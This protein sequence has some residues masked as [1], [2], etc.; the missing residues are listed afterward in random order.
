MIL[1]PGQ[2]QAIAAAKDW[3]L[4]QT[5]TTLYLDGPAGT[6]KTTIAKLLA[7]YAEKPV[8]AAYTGRAA[9]QIAKK[10]GFP[11][12][13]LHSLLY[14]PRRKPNG[15]VEFVFAPEESL[16][17][18]TDL[19][20]IDEASM[21]P[22]TMEQ[23]L[24]HF[25]CR[26]LLIGDSAQLPP[27]TR[28]GGLIQGRRP[29]I[30]LTEIHRQAKDNPVLMLATSVREGKGLMTGRF[31]NSCVMSV[32]DPVK[33]AVES[34]AS[35]V[36]AGMRKTVRKLN[37][38]FRGGDESPPRSGEPVLALQNLHDKGIMN[39]SLWRLA[40]RKATG[41]ED[42]AD[43]LSEAIETFAPQL[44]PDGIT[45]S[46][47]PPSVELPRAGS[48]LFPHRS[49][50]SLSSLETG[51]ELADV[52][53]DFGPAMGEEYSYARGVCALDFGYCLTVHKSQGSE[54][55]EVCLINESG[56]F[57]DS[58]RQWLYTG[59]TRASENVLVLNGK[60]S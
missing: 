43:W 6:G 44:A 29:D 53:A 57:R 15:G 35:M 30:R 56:V 55:P 51:I 16:L 33:I 10:S 12:Y 20:V 37:V 19:L 34:K 46:Y 36:L 50:V 59:L 14:K 32:K 27:P 45:K 52:Y 23:E 47:S 2:E 26:I 17:L 58:A 24:L 31:G 42:Q 25:D 13:T 22:T 38:A 7:E 3:F 60:V 21:V 39:G 41:G 1:S 54:W 4:N 40:G 28:S 9:L 49:Y 8:F 18:D 5:S 11:A 48:S